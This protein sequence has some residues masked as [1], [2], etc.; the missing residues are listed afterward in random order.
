VPGFEKSPAALV[1]RFNTVLERHP[2]VQRRQM[3]GYPAAFIGG[4]MVTSLFNDHWV[5]RLP[6]ADREELLAIDG[7]GPF[8]PM[9]DRPM[10][11]YA[12]VPSSIVADDAALD[13]WLERAFAHGRSLP[14][15]KK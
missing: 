13:V 12:I 5:I 3:F 2:D 10:K 6:D 7:A 4:N 15:K 14:P 9:P 1:E 8:A 11:G